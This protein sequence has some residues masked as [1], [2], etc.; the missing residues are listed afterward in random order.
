MA[1]Q[2]VLHPIALEP[3]DQGLTEAQQATFTLCRCFDEMRILFQNLL[4]YCLA[5]VTSGTDSSENPRS[6]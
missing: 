4:E 6:S 5:Q 2:V 3:A 1:Q